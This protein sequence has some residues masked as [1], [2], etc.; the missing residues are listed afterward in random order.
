MQM[1]NK[2]FFITEFGAVPGSTE[3]QTEEIQRAIDV[4]FQNGGGP[5]VVPAGVYLTGDIRLRSNCTL[6]LKTGATLKG[7]RNP[8][9]Y[10]GYLNDKIEPLDGGE[11]TNKLWKRTE[12]DA[13]K[14]Y[15]FLQKPGSRWNHALIKAIHAENVAIIG[16]ENA[17]LDG[18]DCFDELGEENYRGPHCINMFYCKNVRLRAIPLRTARTGQ[19]RFFT[20]KMLSQ[21]TFPLL[22]VMTEY[23]L[24]AAKTLKLKIVI[25]TRATTALRDLQ[26][27]MFL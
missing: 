21:K 10:F 5:I 13:V 14:D 24:Q 1:N 16:E 18:S 3:L 2:Q 7:S 8:E 15:E 4:C 9:D 6:Y 20:V 27:Q 12:M 25:F 23:I 26:T 22:L 11:I 19:M 17:F